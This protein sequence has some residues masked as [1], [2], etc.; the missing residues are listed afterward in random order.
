[1][2]EGDEPPARPRRLTRRLRLGQL[3]WAL[4]ALPLAILLASVAIGLITV[5][6]QGSVRDDLLTRV[7]PANSAALKLATAVVN[8]ETGIRGYE[9]TGRAGFLQPYYLGIS[10]QMTDVAHLERYA[11]PGTKQ[12]VAVLLA[13]ITTWDRLTAQPAL[14]A[15]RVGRDRRGTIDVSEAGKARFDAIRVALTALQN[16]ISA[17]VRVV[18]RQLTSS[19]KTTTITLSVIAVVLLL[20]F[21]GAGWA[22]RR[23]VTRPLD[24]LTEE[25]R[26]V[27][28]GE[29]QRSLRVEGPLDIEE[30]GHD[31]DRMRLGLLELLD[32]ATTARNQLAE[33][34]IE[35]ERSNAELEQFA[36]V[37]SHDL[38][39]PLRKVTSFCQMLQQRYAGQLDD[40]ADRYIEFAVDGALRMQQLVNDL[41]AFSRVGRG[42]E[43]RRPIDLTSLVKAAVSDLQ[44][45][46]DATGAEVRI[47]PLPTLPVE[48]SLLR[49]VFQNL[50]GNAVK[51]HGDEPPR[52]RID[53]TRLGDTWRFSC[54]DNGIGIEPEYAERVFVI[55]QRL[56]P[57][58]RYAGTGI[59]L[60]MCRK[61]VEYHGGRIW[62]DTTSHGGTR[63]L[64]TLPAASETMAA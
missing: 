4:G 42:G 19:A 63:I 55:F 15:A 48:P 49:A 37:A 33:T 39:E 30:L 53:V 17:R 46:I 32:S 1:M 22:L 21:L 31:L 7:E 2:S 3:L 35:L 64:F 44:E 25:S 26:R 28:G 6:G 29:L 59:G 27:A 18:K 41:L 50:I 23:V 54:T 10:Q 45:A 13:R 60:A 62:L 36:Y 9:L 34:A 43:A 8:Q 56:H 38:Q 52:I 5:A 12:D 61:I 40:R 24:R 57:R 11:I 58:D 20:T 14:R 51:F 16:D 47:E